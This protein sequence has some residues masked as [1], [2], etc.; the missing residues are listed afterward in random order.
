MTT[1]RTSISLCMIVKNEE[2][3]LPR[4]LASAAPYVDEIVVVDTGSND[5]T[6]EIAES[7]G[8]KVRHF[9]WVD[10]FAAARNESLRH[11]TGEW[12]LQLDA[13]ERLNLLGCST[14]LREAAGAPGVDAYAVMIRCHHGVKSSN[15][16]YG[17][18][19]NYR[20]FRRIPG[21]QYEKPVH[22]SVDHS[23]RR[24]GAA[25]ANAVF[26]IDHY[27][28]DIDPSDLNRKLER[29]LTILERT[30]EKTPHDPFVLYYL[31]NT[32]EALGRTGESLDVLKRGLELENTPD[33]LQAMLLNTMGRSYLFAG[34]Y[35][36]TIETSIRSLDIE[37]NQNTARYYIGLAY[38]NQKLYN[39]ALPY[40]F[41]C[42]EYCLLPAEKKATGLPQEHTMSELELIK[43]LAMCLFHKKDFS[44]AV[45]FSLSFLQKH[46]E[47]A[48]VHHILG[49]SY[50]NEQQYSTALFHL[51]K[52]YT[53]GVKGHEIQSALA[54]C[55]LKVGEIEKC[56]EWLVEMDSETSESIRHLFVLLQLIAEQPNIDSQLV[57]VLIQK[58]M[59]LQ[60]ATFEQL[61]S[62]LSTLARN[63]SLDAVSVVLESIC[64]R[65]A[66]VESFMA[67]LTEYFAEQNR[68]NA[69]YPI[70]EAL[71][72]RCPR[73]TPFLEALGI[74]C[75]KM[76]NPFRAIEV[77][78]RLHHLN[79]ESIAYSRALAGLYVSVGNEARAL[80]VISDPRPGGDLTAIG[81]HQGP[82]YGEA[83]T[84]LQDKGFE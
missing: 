73:V 47:D 81:G 62:L 70:L 40:L 16:C 36:K 22:E 75:I 61:G 60:K 1:G 43:L 77:Y 79:P 55:A 44:N 64:Q 30:A 83:C 8:A 67:G 52:A 11:A 17:V 3:T 49:L 71:V 51:D 13:D 26:V 42:Y 33:I 59:I 74:I 4:C 21:I 56:F 34:D 69:F 27:G 46:D 41:S 54:C 82:R 7:F 9:E 58:K 78:G 31:A 48:D 6:V 66:E 57:Q 10:D 19:H 24:F 20:F 15:A 50:Y 68:M 18:N 37:S 29:N 45:S 35:D 14:G 76:G 63:G 32:Y 65:T 39:L 25:T 5:R 84:V 53:L 80:Q 2:E 38:Y 72:T 28:Y 12:V 23:L